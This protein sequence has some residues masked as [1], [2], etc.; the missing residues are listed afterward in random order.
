MWSTDT[1]GEANHSFNIWQ[2]CNGNSGNEIL[3]VRES[4][5]SLRGEQPATWP[6]SPGLAK[7]LLDGS[8]NFLSGIWLRALPGRDVCPTW[9]HT[10]L[11]CSFPICSEAWNGHLSV[12]RR[13]TCILPLCVG[14]TLYWLWRTSCPIFRKLDNLL[15]AIKWTQQLGKLQLNYVKTKTEMH[16]THFLIIFL[17]SMSSCIW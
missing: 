5:L 7:C 16:K 8:A 4:R 3:A 2:C 9:L 11:C 12:V 15:L 14:V 1:Q 6:V 13:A 17:L 10:H